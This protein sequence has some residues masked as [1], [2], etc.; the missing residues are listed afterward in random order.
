MKLFLITIFWKQ[1]SHHR[2]GV[3]VHTLKVTFQLIK[4]KHYRMVL[5]GLL[6]DIGK[7]FVAYQKPEDILNNEYSFTDHEEKSFKIIEHWP[8]ISD[9]TKQLVRWHYLIRKMDKAKKKSIKDGISSGNKEYLDCYSLYISFD[10]QFKNDLR[11]FLKCD[12]LG[13]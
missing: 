6:H 11:N 10:N 9:Y 8:L 4:H 2:H 1:N 5:A 3:L 7:P 12:D 13:K